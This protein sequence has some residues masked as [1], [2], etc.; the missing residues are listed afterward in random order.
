MALKLG[1]SLSLPQFG[2]EFRR[3]HKR[4]ARVWVDKLCIDPSDMAGACPWGHGG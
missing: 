3:E 1:L 2:E 4:D